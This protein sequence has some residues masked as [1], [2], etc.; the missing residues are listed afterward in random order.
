MGPYGLGASSHLAVYDIE[1]DSDSQPTI[2]LTDVN[3]TCHRIP[4]N[5]F[6]SLFGLLPSMSSADSNHIV[7]IRETK[8]LASRQ[9][10]DVIS[11]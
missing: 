8:P 11:N 7:N 4:Q 1:A 3:S 6:K 9:D 5:Q 2:S 10:C